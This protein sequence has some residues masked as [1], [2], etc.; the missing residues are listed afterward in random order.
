MTSAAKAQLART[1]RALRERLLAELGESLR[2]TY[3]LGLSARQARTGRHRPTV[4]AILCVVT[5]TTLGALLVLTACV[6]EPASPEPDWSWQGEQVTIH[7]YGITEEEVCG[8]TLDETDAFAARIAQWHGFDP[9]ALDLSIHWIDKARFEDEEWCAPMAFGCV[10]DGEVHT[11]WLPFGHELSHAVDHAMGYRSFALALAE[12][13]AA[14]HSDPQLGGPPTPEDPVTEEDLPGDLRDALNE[15]EDLPD[16]S[17][18]L[19]VSGHFVSYLLETHGLDAVHELQSRAARGITEPEWDDLFQDVL[20]ASYEEVLSGYD[21]YPLCSW[22]AYRS[23]VWECSGE[24]DVIAM[25]EMDPLTFNVDLSCD[26]P[27]AV[28]GSPSTI[29]VAH[30]LAVPDPGPD[31]WGEHERLYRIDVRRPGSAALEFGVMLV[32]ECGVPCS[33]EPRVWSIPGDLD[34]IEYVGWSQHVY[35]LRPGVYAL[36]LFGA[37]ELAVTLEPV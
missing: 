25:P 2:G 37:G 29:R 19:L 22:N 20:G 7:A 28:G 34:E 24:A 11:P 33:E 16:G 9:A 1:I 36:V 21:E 4:P 13:L 6:D 12:G 35:T 3:K 30:R 5:R 23:K 17:F 32:E 8:G 10:R 15:T 18:P 14:I 27:R 26:N 31:E